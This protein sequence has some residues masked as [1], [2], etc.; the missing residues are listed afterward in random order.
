MHRSQVLP[1]QWGVIALRTARDT[2]GDMA[3]GGG[4]IAAAPA[5]HS[6]TRSTSFT[7]VSLYG[8]NKSYSGTGTTGIH[9]SLIYSNSTMYSVLTS[10]ITLTVTS[11]YASA[12]AAFFEDYLPRAGLTTADYEVTST[13][14]Q[15]TLELEMARFSG[16]TINQAHFEILMG[17]VGV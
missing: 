15:M 2:A 10:N 5:D 9:T 11:N 1:R 8:V 14:T 17:E 16:I 12:W 3:Q 7:Q 6:E 13:A 4:P